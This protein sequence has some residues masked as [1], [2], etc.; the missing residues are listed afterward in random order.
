MQNFLIKKNNSK[1]YTHVF[2]LQKY[3]FR[4]CDKLITNFH[5]PKSTLILLITAF[6]GEDWKKL[7]KFVINNDY[8]FLSFGDSSLLFKK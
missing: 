5:Y 8:R 6:I 2:I 7:Y 1:L 3:K 4:L